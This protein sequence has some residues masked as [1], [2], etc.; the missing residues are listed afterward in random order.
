MAFYITPSGVHR[1]ASGIEEKEEACEKIVSSQTTLI[2]DTL[3]NQWA[4]EHANAFSKEVGAS[5]R[6]MYD[7]ACSATADICNYTTNIIKQY[8]QEE[9]NYCPP[10]YVTAVPY[11]QNELDTGTPTTLP[12]GESIGVA[13]GNTVT[14]VFNT[15][16]EYFTKIA[17]AYKDYMSGVVD[18]IRDSGAF[19][20][21]TVSHCSSVARRASLAFDAELESCKNACKSRT[22]AEMD[23][24][25]ATH[26]RMTGD[27][28]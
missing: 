12:D 13:E 6:G 2:I 14:N 16:N 19:D 4:S 1:I 17:D 22:D 7:W 23:S 27:Q 20:E 9:G 15:L 8:E 10:L 21:H 28:A 5:V 18:V 11:P 25:N 3:T 26:Q 24:K